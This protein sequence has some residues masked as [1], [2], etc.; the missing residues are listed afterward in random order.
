MAEIALSVDVA[1]PPELVFDAL[2][3][4]TG[5]GEWMAGTRVRV[6]RGDGRSVG[7]RILARTALGRLGFDDPMEITAWDRPRRVQVHHLGN[8]VRGDGVFEVEALADGTSRFHWVEWLDLP[9]GRFGLLGFP[10]VRPL[11]SRAILPSLRA[12][13]RWA[14]QRQGVTGRA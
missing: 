1:A 14:E 11:L 6:T 12:F 7:S 8:V 10:V 9:L 4:W 13:G 5:Q 3:D 2:T